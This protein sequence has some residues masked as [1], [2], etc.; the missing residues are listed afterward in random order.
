MRIRIIS[1]WIFLLIAFSS[2]AQNKKAK[3]IIFDSDMG[4]DY[5]DVGAITMLH[6]FAD[7][8]Y[9]NILA[10]M[11]STQYE[12]VAGVFN[13]LNTYFNRPQLPI[14][15]PRK[16]GLKLKDGQHWTDTVLANYPHAIKSNAEVPEASELYR[17]ILS[18]QP[19]KS[20]TII[21]VGFFT[22]LA[23]LL[24]SKP[25][26]YSKLSGRDLVRKKVK[27]LISMAGRFPTGKEFN[28]E[29]DAAASQIVF[30]QWPT[31]ILLSGFEIG[32]K[33]KVGLALVRNQN[34]SNSPVKDVFRISIPQAKEDSAGRM[35]WDETAVL[36]GAKGYQ[37]YYTLKEGKMV[38]KSD[39]SNSW[40]DTGQGHAYLVEKKPFQ[41]VRNE[42]EKL[43]QHQPV[44]KKSQ[45]AK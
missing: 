13:V 24:Q 19:D 10:T 3:A 26:R 8:G 4:P 1:I 38:V 17:K 22:N 37:Q 42:I 12:G 36:I 31:R 32:Q 30:G 11:A 16:N 45:V 5:D 20:V 27:E 7:S 34:I 2:V 25:D 18:R 41:E 44:K 29:K 28:V 15:I 35:S 6:A 21:T 33:I 23:N 43:I 14:G 40:L 9:I 39:G